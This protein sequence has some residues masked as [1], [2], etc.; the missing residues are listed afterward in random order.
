MLLAVLVVGLVT[1]VLVMGRGTGLRF[2]GAWDCTKYNFTVQ[3]NGDVYVQNSSTNPEPSTG[4][5]VY[6][7]A[8]KV[9]TLTAPA[10]TANSTTVKIGTVVVPTSGVFTWR[11][12]AKAD[13]RCDD[14]GQYIAPLNC[15]YYEIKVTP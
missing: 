11:A 6:I 10:T 1:T 5:D 4:V 13:A 7:N 2:G 3:Q 8:I 15:N 14:S 9:S 12:V